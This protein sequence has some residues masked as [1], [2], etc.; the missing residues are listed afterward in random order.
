MDVTGGMA[1]KVNQMLNL[2]QLHPQM[3]IQIFSAENPD[4]LGLAF[5]GERKGTR[6][7]ND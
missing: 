6:I 5:Q 1:E 2:V 3:E 7:T 4:D